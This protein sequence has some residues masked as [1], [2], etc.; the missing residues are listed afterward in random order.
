M[1][2]CYMV[3]FFVSSNFD[4]DVENVSNCPLASHLTAVE[5]SPNE[6]ESKFKLFV[7]PT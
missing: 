5:D 1:E 6:D 4:N 2:A 3:C 7:K